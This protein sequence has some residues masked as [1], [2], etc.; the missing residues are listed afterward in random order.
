MVMTSLL[1]C[2]LAGEDGCSRC[3]GLWSCWLVTPVVDLFSVMY[4]LGQGKSLVFEFDRGYQFSSASAMPRKL[5]E[6]DVELVLSLI[7][8]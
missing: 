4:I 1:D 8:K 2:I 7:E 5:F 6:L 3:F